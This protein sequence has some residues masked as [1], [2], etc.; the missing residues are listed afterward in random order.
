[1]ESLR[2]VIELAAKIPGRLR[3]VNF[4]SIWY[5]N[6]SLVDLTSITSVTRRMFMKKLSLL[7]FI[8]LFAAGC[9]SRENSDSPILSKVDGKA[10]TKEDFLKEIN[11]M[12]EWARGRFT[13]EEGKKQFLEE[14]IK[15]ELIYQDAKKNGL[16][17]DDEY[18][19]RVEEFKKM[20]LVKMA[21]EKEVEEKTQLPPEAAKDFYD[22]NPGEFMVGRE[23]RAKHIL[24]GSEEEAKKIH[25]RIQKGEDFSTLAKKFSKDKGTAKKGGDLGFFRQGKMVPEFEIVAFNLKVGSVSKPIKTRFGHHIIKVIDRKE[26]R[27][28]SY[29]EVKDALSKR[30][31]MEKQKELFGSYIETLKNSFKVESDE[32]ITELK[33]LQLGEASPEAK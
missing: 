5:K 26:G 23:V 20:T 31:A 13:T 9:S 32:Y 3:V 4:Q 8:V 15:R 33:D 29:D 27:Q 24:V 17:R 1:M 2:H 28:G 22:K 10:I 21:L 25:E 19:K 11:R 7:I 16:H 6:T 30:L 12:P 18:K 14:L